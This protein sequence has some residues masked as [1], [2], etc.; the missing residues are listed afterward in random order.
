MQFNPL[1]GKYVNVNFRKIQEL[2]ADRRY[3]IGNFR[4]NVGTL[5]DSFCEKKVNLI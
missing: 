3:K 4:M 1:T 2:Y 5:L